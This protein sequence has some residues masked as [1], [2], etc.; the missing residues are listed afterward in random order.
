MGFD[1]F[2]VIDDALD[3]LQAAGP[4]DPRVLQ[5]AADV[6]MKVKALAEKMLSFQPAIED[7]GQESGGGVIVSLG[8]AAVETGKSRLRLRQRRVSLART[9]N[10]EQ[11][12]DNIDNMPV[13]VMKEKGWE[14][15]NREDI[16]DLVQSFHAALLNCSADVE[17]DI[18]LWFDR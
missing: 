13:S 3:R 8:E 1:D 6:R 17:R 9:A 18:G 15:A 7:E 16:V 4:E 12:Q 11:M 10:K 14:Q 5:A 2:E